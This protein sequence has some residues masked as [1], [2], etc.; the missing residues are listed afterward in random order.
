MTTPATHP[1]PS[2]PHLSDAAPR[3]PWERYG[4]VMGVVWLVFLVFPV[5]AVLSAD[6]QWA[7][8]AAGLVLLAVFAVVYT[9]GFVRLG[10]TQEWDSAPAWGW[11]Y[12]V[13]LVLVVAGVMAVVGTGAIGMMPY[14]VSMAMFV[15]PWRAALA[16]YAGSVAVTAVGAS[17]VGSPRSDEGG[18]W[19]QVIIVVLVG[20]I[21]T[22]VRALDHAGAEHR[23]LTANLTMA[24][25]RDRV[26]RDVHDVLGHSLTV[27]TVKAELAERLVTTDPARAQAELAEIQ[28]ITR[29][30][31]AE[32]RATVGGLRVARLTDEID[33]ARR[34]L[35]DAGIG[36]ELPG[37]PSVVDPRHRVV[38]AWALREAVTNVVR[39]SSAATCR[40]ELGP[41]RLTVTDDGQ[42]LRGRGEGNGLSGLRERI[43][44]AGGAVDVRP[45]PEGRGTTMQVQL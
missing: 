20:A 11:R 41:D 10:H 13:V 31:L 21:T 35:D 43:A 33:A 15:L 5:L 22:V 23:T 7:W 14:V 4:W 39:H 29:Q 28:A 8:R 32:I 30:S 18:V 37:D 40:V 1:S 26:A 24:T 6:R 16:T 38:L 12:V 25:E 27:V 34:A 45:G 36:A 19:V 3:D 42:G 2:E 9:H 44:T 17:I